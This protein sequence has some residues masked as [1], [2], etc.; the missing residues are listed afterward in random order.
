MCH[1]ENFNQRVS[2]LQHQQWQF[3]SKFNISNGQKCFFFFTKASC[4][5]CLQISLPASHQPLPFSHQP[6][7]Q[8]HYCDQHDIPDANSKRLKNRLIRNRTSPAANPPISPTLD[9]IWKQICLKKDAT[10]LWIKDIFSNTIISIIKSSHH[11]PSHIPC[12][13]TNCIGKLSTKLPFVI[14]MIIIIIIVIL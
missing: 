1:L 5:P 13:A 6:D 4:Q 9:H 7:R 12:L 8:H 11:L 14:M 10:H 3:I 2:T